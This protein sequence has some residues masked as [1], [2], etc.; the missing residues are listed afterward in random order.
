VGYSLN[1]SGAGLRQLSPINFL[2]WWQVCLFDKHAVNHA[3]FAVF[4]FI[5]R[6]IDALFS[7]H[8]ILRGQDGQHNECVTNAV[9]D[10]ATVLACDASGQLADLLHQLDKLLLRRAAVD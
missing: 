4:D 1:C 10:C 2:L 8:A 5:P 3:T 7:G 6:C 9:H